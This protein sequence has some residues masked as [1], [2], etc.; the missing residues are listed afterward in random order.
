MAYGASGLIRLAGGSGFNLWGYQ[1]VDAIATVNS[2]NYFNGAANMLNVR[3]VILV[4]DSNAP[5]L[6]RLLILQTVLQ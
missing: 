6:V 3:D 5:T 1:T 4:V 2:A